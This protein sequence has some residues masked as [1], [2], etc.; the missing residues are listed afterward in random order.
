MRRTFALAR[1]NL[2][3]PGDGVGTVERT[4]RPA[5]NF[6][7]FDLV[8]GNVFQ[9]RRSHG[10]RGQALAI[11]KHQRLLRTAAAYAD[12]GRGADTAVGRDLQPGLGLQQAGQAGLRRALDLLAGDD[13]DIARQNARAL[14]YARCGDDDR[15]LAGGLDRGC[16]GNSNGQRSAA[17]S[18]LHEFLPRSARD[19][20]GGTTETIKETRGGS[21]ARPAHCFPAVFPPVAQGRSPGSWDRICRLPANTCLQWRLDRPALTYRCGGSTG[22][23]ATARRTCFPFHPPAGSAGGHLERVAPCYT[24]SGPIGE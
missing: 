8:E 20:A 22:L 7:A 18:I 6:Y 12:G 1:E 21:E 16:C 17:Q 5:Q 10:R 24:L 2:D 15:V 23:G 3:Y 13:A 14:G 9:R 4:R 11:D 19:P